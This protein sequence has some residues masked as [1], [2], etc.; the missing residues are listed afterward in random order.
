[1]KKI[2]FSMFC[3]FGVL[4]QLQSQT[5]VQTVRGTVNDAGSYKP[6]AFAN[7][8]ILG[9]NPLLGAVC[10]SNGTFVITSVPVGRYDIRITYTGYETFVLKEVIVSSGKETKLDILLRQT[11]GMLKEVIV[12]STVSK[13]QALNPMATASARMLSVDEASRYAG[14][15]DDP[16]RLVTSF[17]GIASNINSNGIVVRGNAPK[18]L[19]WK[20]EGI[21]IPNPNHFADLS[22]FGGGG[23]TALSSRLLA[24]SDFFAGA[25]P[26]EYGNAL[27][28]VF[29]IQMRNGNNQQTEY[30]AQIGIIGVEFA[31]EGPF[32]KGKQ[33][34]YNFNYRYSTLGLLKPLLPE[35]GDGVSYQ[36]W[37][38]KINIP[39]PKA[40][41]FS[42]WGIGLNDQS[43]AE[44]SSDS[45]GCI[46][47][48]D[49]EEQKVKQYMAA[50]GITHKV[51]FGRNTLLKN[52]LAATCNGINYKTG[53][54]N[55]IGEITPENNIENI[56]T[57]FIFSSSLSSHPGKKHSNKSGIEVTT[58]AYS[59]FLQNIGNQYQTLTTIVNKNGYSFLTSFYS[60]SS[61]LLKDNLRI[62]TG[63]NFQH[64]ALNG[65]ITIEPRLGAK[66]Q[67]SKCHSLSIAY[68][69]HS[70][71]E[72]I[73]YYFTMNTTDG[74]LYNKSLSFTKANHWVISYDFAPRENIHFR[75]EPY[76]QYLFK[77]P[78]ISDSSF[79][80]INM[81]ADWFF[82][83]KVV[84]KGKGLNYGIDLTYEKYLSH[85]YYYM[86]TASV[87]DSR[88]TGGDGIWR[89]TRFNRR[90]LFNALGGKEWQTGK[91]KQN[92]F[93]VN[94]RASFQGGDRYS[95]INLL[96]SQT[97]KD[98]VFDE[99]RAFSLQYPSALTIHTTIC[100]TMNR[101]KS[102][103][104]VALKIINATNFKEYLGFRYNLKTG[105]SDL[106]REAIMIPSLSYRIDF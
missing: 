6:L 71:L 68:G 2:V 102:T 96:A 19:Q 62:N 3:M 54:L 81:Q 49:M 91:S 86:L 13:N 46:Y 39:T 63:I 44:A 14:G 22:A 33:A 65:N 103:H 41:V 7:I 50:G 53:I 52:S 104:E 34:S 60:Q 30:S 43:G 97:T 42:V 77:V 87:F 8:I 9:T 83:E 90:F 10:D 89:S 5:P 82:N 106:Y 35:N 1:M 11:S 40:G 67:V 55:A 64:F 93:A 78:V 56:V 75:A 58:L 69:L 16:A 73:Q 47:Q 79:S 28:G 61:Y 37:A 26:A 84:N 38:F 23:L 74:T 48:Y 15:F 85:G 25:F 101:Q 76:I 88:Y 57:H 105:Q 21:E 99:S 17:A 18:A 95:P 12:R 51:W 36:D 4:V 24:N 80:F 98:I 66:W 100:Y 94:F 59:L 27:S 31:S 92:I 45:L 70:R 72:G 20:L 32:R 29:D